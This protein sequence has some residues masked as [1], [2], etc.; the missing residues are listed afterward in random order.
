MRRALAT[1]VVGL[2][3]GTA[4]TG[5]TEVPAA[6]VANPWFGFVHTVS[7]GVD[8]PPEVVVED[9]DFT[10]RTDSITRWDYA[11]DWEPQVDQATS[12]DPFS[13]IMPAFA[14]GSISWERIDTQQL[15]YKIGDG[16]GNYSCHQV[17]TVSWAG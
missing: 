6:A 11:M 10:Y 13:T 12:T 1:I 2:L 8:N 17:T 4:L 15:T 5:V 14:S 3:G 9:R 16:T 7:A